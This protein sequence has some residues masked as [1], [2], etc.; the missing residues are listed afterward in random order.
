MSLSSV[1]G[2][3][4]AGGRSRRMG[5]N[6]ALLPV[7]G[8]TSRTFVEQLATLLAVL[9]PEVLLVAR[10][11]TSGQEYASLSHTWR[12][13][14][15][16]LP[17][18]GPLMGLASGLQATTCSHALVVAVDLPWVQ[19]ALL[20]WL[21][22]YP[23]TDELLIPHVQGIPQVLLARYPRAIL[24]MIETCLHAGRRDPRALLDLVPVRF[25]PEEQLRVA[26]PELR[27]FMNVNTPEDFAQACAA[28]G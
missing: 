1:A 4:L 14:Y 20:A 8:S 27:S 10:D 9:C 23:R 13:V 28:F 25:L 19:P 16:H 24:P 22:A 5:T 15:D 6:K 7:P 11:E 26:D 3:I 18:Q 2:I 17:D 21:S 12:I